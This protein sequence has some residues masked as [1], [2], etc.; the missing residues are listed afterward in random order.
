MTRAA[1]PGFAEDMG[2]LKEAL[3][4]DLADLCVS[5][6]DSGCWEFVPAWIGAFLIASSNSA[7]QPSDFTDNKA[8]RDCGVSLRADFFAWNDTKCEE[9]CTNKGI[10]PKTSEGPGSDRPYGKRAGCDGRFGVK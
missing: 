6:K 5:L 9:C 3:D 4:N 1:G 7:D 8:G 2:K 10:G